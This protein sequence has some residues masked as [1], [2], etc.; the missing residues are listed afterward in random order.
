LG[1][2]TLALLSDLRGAKEGFAEADLRWWADDLKLAA[3][4]QAVRA[5]A[6]HNVYKA[7]LDHVAHI[8]VID[9]QQVGVQ[10]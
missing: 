10:G 5:I 4:W 1:S 7:W 2:Y 8:L 3:Q 6:D 9:G